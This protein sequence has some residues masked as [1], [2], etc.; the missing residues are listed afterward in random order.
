MNSGFS[1]PLTLSEQK[2]NLKRCLKQI[3]YLLIGFIGVRHLL[4]LFCSHIKEVS[5]QAEV[6][7][8]QDMDANV[9]V[10][11]TSK[12]SSTGETSTELINRNK[13]S[14]G[15]KVQDH[16]HPTVTLVSLCLNA[17]D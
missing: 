16:K 15:K 13:T 6:L 12:Y 2:A 11:T 10:L 5:S 14:G 1:L 8:C 4:M 9:K 3:T 7:C 17:S